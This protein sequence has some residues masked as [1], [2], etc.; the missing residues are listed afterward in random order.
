MRRIRALLDACI[1][2]KGN[3]SNVFFDLALKDQIALHWTPEV[4]EEFVKNWTAIQLRKEG[5]PTND[6]SAQDDRNR[7]MKEIA[8]HNRL[9]LFGLMQPEWRI[10][11]WSFEETSKEYSLSDFGVGAPGG[12]HH[13]D[14]HVALA[15]ATL[16]KTFPD[17]EV[18]LVTENAKHLPNEILSRH[19]VW[20]I[21]QSMA[22][23]TLFNLD[24][25]AVCQAIEQTIADTRRPELSKG[26]M[27]RVISASTGFACPSVAA[28]LQQRWGVKPTAGK[29]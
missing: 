14:I 5:A 9:K 3:V 18:W 1:L 8:A 11:S 22:L 29:N 26:D 17:D 21:H 16:A 10:P 27:L 13:G 23:Q 28:S 6:H 7:S 24:Q 15:A 19:G 12:V 2:I 25:E 4:G 20:S